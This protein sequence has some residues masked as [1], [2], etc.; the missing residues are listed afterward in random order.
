MR[1]GKY[2]A[3]VDIFVM[4]ALVLMKASWYMVLAPLVVPIVVQ[5]ARYTIHKW[6]D[7]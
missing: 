1:K 7:K 4:I 6:M 3:D 5:G 2:V